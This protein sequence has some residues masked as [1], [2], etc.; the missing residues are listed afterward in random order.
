MPGGRQRVD[1]LE[2]GGLPTVAAS[3]RITLRRRRSSHATPA[4]IAAMTSA[5]GQTLSANAP[6][7]ITPRAV[8]PSAAFTG[9]G[10]AVER[11]RPI[12]DSTG[13][14]MNRLATDG[15]A[16]GTPKVGVVG[17]PPDPWVEDLEPGMRVG[18]LHLEV[19]GQ[20]VRLPGP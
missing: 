9:W 8:A 11:N 20:R 19:A 2:E 6:A 14:A 10:T 7:A 18:L 16:S 13:P 3:D 12:A 1:E 17:H 15:A 5:N 4:A